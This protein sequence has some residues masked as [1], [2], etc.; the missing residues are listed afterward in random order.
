VRFDA[1]LLTGVLLLAACSRGGDGKKPAAPQGGGRFDAVQAAPRK[2][3]DARGFCEKTYPADGP[4]ARKWTPPPDQPLPAGVKTAAPGAGKR[5]TYV[6]LWATWCQPCIQEMGLFARWSEAF[7]K[8]GV[9]VDFQLVSIDAPDAADAL[10]ERVRKGLPGTV[11]WLRGDDDLGPLLD[12]LGVERTAAI[13]IHAVVDP[14]GMLRCVR[15]GAIHSEDYP[16]VKALV[17]G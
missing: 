12:S 3:V 6:N 17:G 2:V 5:W 7:R 4:D 1:A 13:P 9:P 11:R 16:A 15:V 10:A 14:E 8:E